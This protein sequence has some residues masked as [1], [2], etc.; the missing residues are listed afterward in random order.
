MDMPKLVIK[1]ANLW[2]SPQSPAF[3]PGRFVTR[4]E[5]ECFQS[6]SGETYLDGQAYPLSRGCTLFCRPGQVR[7]SRLPFQTLFLYFDVSSSDPE[8]DG[9]LS[10]I[11]PLTPAH[12]AEDFSVETA[13]KRICRLFSRADYAAKLERQALLMELLCR[14]ARLSEPSAPQFPLNHQMEFYQPIFFMKENVCRPLCA[15]EL[16]A[17]VGYSAAHFTV[18]FREMVH[19]TPYDY[20]LRLKCQE[21]E[22]RLREGSQSIQQI[23]A[24][25]GFSSPGY[26]SCV[27]RRICGCAPSQIRRRA[28]NEPYGSL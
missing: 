16:A 11:P 8:I 1:N 3:S 26:F 10:R 5:L 12:F 13:M 22:R 14:L 6:E 2:S 17:C 27:F 9:L 24:E 21:A 7:F 19:R 15:E 28:E 4:Y 25:L 23:A 18:L 20:F